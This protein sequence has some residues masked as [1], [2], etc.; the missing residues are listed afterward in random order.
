M[1]DPLLQ[2]YNGRDLA[3][4]NDAGINKALIWGGV[5][6]FIYLCSALH[7]SVEIQLIS[8]E[9]HWAECQYINRHHPINA[10]V[11]PMLTGLRWSY[12]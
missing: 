2:Y 10:L 5:C 1:V 6:L 11:T 12:P 8:T 3:V 7:I 4:L 9:I